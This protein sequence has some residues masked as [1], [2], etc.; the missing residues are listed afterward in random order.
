MMGFVVLVIVM[1]HDYY[2]LINFNNSDIVNMDVNIFI[3]VMLTFFVAITIRAI[4][5]YNQVIS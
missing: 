1:L 5:I 2:C 3:I 4:V